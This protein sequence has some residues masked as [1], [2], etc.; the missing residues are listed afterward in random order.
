LKVGILGGSFD[1]LHNAHLHLAAAAQLALGLQQVVFVVAPVPPHKNAADLTPAPHR[2]AMVCR[3]L[4]AHPNFFASAVELEDP[5]NPFTV[6]TLAKLCR[7]HD[8]QPEQIFFIAG[9]DSLKFFST[10]RDWQELLAGRYH[11][12]FVR[13]PGLEFDLTGL[14]LPEAIRARFR[15]APSPEDLPGTH[16]WLELNAPDI[17]GTVIRARVA[18]GEDISGLVPAEVVRHISKYGLY[19]DDKIK[20]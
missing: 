6:V 5:D 10:W 19:G 12:V 20:R 7:K 16:Y 17:S 8:W 1:P 18:A 9:G 14:G 4:E 15:T 11:F 13:R 3:A 2:F